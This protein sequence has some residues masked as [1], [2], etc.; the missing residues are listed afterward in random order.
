MHRFVP[1][2]LSLVLLF[3]QGSIARAQGQARADLYPVDASAFPAVSALLDVFDAG[4]IFVTGL[5]PE[6]VTVLEDGETLP[7]QELTEQAVPA[8]IVVAINPGP[9]LDVRDG[10][11]VS[12]FQRITQALGI[13]AQARPA[14]LPDDISLVTIAGPIITHASAT[15]WQVSLSSFQ[16]DFRATTPN[17]QSLSIAIDTAS[18]QVPRAGMKRALLF[19]TPHMEDPNLENALQPLIQRAVQ[20]R[21]RVY[22]WFVDA[23]SYFVTTS[24]AQF[25]NLALQTGGALF[26]YSGSQPLPDPEVYFGPLRRLYSMKYV[27]A[28]NVGGPHTISLQIQTPGGRIASAEQT[29]DVN[30]QPPNP[31]FVSPPLQITRQPPPEDPFNTK[32]LTPD[33][34]DIDILVEFPDGHARPLVRTTLYVDGQITAENTAEPFDK[35]QWDLSGYRLSGEH[36]LIVEAVDSLGLS[37]T[38]MEFPVTLTV[39]QPPRGPAAFFGKYRQ[40]ITLGAIGL[41]GFALLAVLLTGRLRLPSLR[42]RAA[43]R[44]AFH[45]PV[46]QPVAGPI[47]PLTNPRDKTRRRLPWSPPARPRQVDAPAYLV[48]LSADLQPAPV[49]PLPLA[50]KELTFGTDPV[51]STQV[52][53]DASISPLHARLAQTEAGGFLLSDAGTVAGTWVNFEPVE[54]AGH[55]LRHGDVIHFGQMAFRFELKNPPPV[56]EP[57]ITPE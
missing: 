35:F 25:G 27:S 16:P 57:L 47:E 44:K 29:F 21:V 6:A 22:I 45:D 53:D 4:G 54:P 2:V 33:M 8:Q 11:G 26:T 17:L 23:D 28:V 18:A 56:A 13:W 32:I 19:I 51:Q 49:V 43:A 42:A 37:R 46:T 10:Q 40:A 52:L 3:G 39:I 20:N 5:K 36:K 7:L 1:A 15:D 31:I 12:R 24:A 30:I 38:S 41:A 48:R 9:P 34:Q 55:L 50:E 14:D